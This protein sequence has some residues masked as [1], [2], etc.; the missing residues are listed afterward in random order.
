MLLEPL[1]DGTANV[2]SVEFATNVRATDPVALEDFSQ[3]IAPCFGNAYGNTRRGFWCS[4]CDLLRIHRQAERA[5]LDVLG[6]VHLHPGWHRIGPPGERGLRISEEPTPMDRYM[7]DNSRYPVNMIC[8]LESGAGTVSVSLAA[9][10]PPPE[11]DPGTPCLV[12]SCG[13][14]CPEGAKAFRPPVVYRPFGLTALLAGHSHMDVADRAAVP[15]GSG[16]RGGVWLWLQQVSHPP[17]VDETVSAMLCLA[18]PPRGVPGV[19]RCQC[20]VELRQSGRVG[21]GCPRQGQ[22]GAPGKDRS[23]EKR[24]PP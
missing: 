21:D 15:E 11:D 18:E 3:S 6:S 4:R 2:T 12:W 1:D 14:A 9:W 23:T 16:P 8:Y 5:G 13:S 7:F 10:G 24:R 17:A 19:P 20:A 22:V